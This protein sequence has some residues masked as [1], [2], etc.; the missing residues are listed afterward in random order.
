MAKKVEIKKARGNTI[1]TPA[2]KA[3]FVSAPQAS[4]FDATKQEASIVLSA[5]NKKVLE[6]QLKA[7]ITEN[8]HVIGMDPKAISIPFKED[9][10]SD[11]NSTG[12]YRLK[13]KTGM[14]YPAQFVGADNKRFTPDEDYQ[15]PNGSDIRLSLTPELIATSMF[16]GLTLRLN[17]IKVL[18]L[19]GSYDL[20]FS[21]D[22]EGDYT[23]DG[24]SPDT[25]ETASTTTDD[26]WED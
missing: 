23:Y 21:D 7:F 16:Q 22:D 5:D 3:L 19:S 8:A 2:G 4:Q 25:A 12:Y 13:A 9:T 24:T 10:D 18:K 1:V 20:G 15:L 6:A 17:G 11:G 26:E 14:K